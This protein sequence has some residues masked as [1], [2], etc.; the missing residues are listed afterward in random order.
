MGN[1]NQI[2]Y[3]AHATPGNATDFGDI[4]TASE[5]GGNG[6]SNG[7]RGVTPPNNVNTNELQYITFGS[8]GNAIDFG[9]HTENGYNASGVSNGTRGVFCGNN[10]AIDAMGYITIASLGNAT[11]FGNLT[12]GR[13]DLCTFES[14]TRGVIA[15][16]DASGRSDVIDYIIIA[17]LGNASDFGDMTARNGHPKGC[18]S[19]AGRGLIGGGKDV[20]GGD[21]YTDEIQYVT[22][23]SNGNATDFGDLTRAHGYFACSGNGSIAVW[24]CGY[25]A[26]ANYDTMDY[27][28]IATLGNASDFGDDAHNRRTLCG[29]SGT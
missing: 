27:V 19:A 21:G 13:G 29:M 28:T 26:P 25:D 4:L 20:D 6:C 7:T 1:H 5:M 16:G 3:F 2:T 23:S 18:S 9:N 11:D 12:V 10:A 24:C 15:G 8:L 22:I 14:E 17:S